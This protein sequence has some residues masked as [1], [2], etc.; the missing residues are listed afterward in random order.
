LMAGNR[1]SVAL[2]LLQES[3]PFSVGAADAPTITVQTYLTR[4]G[5]RTAFGFVVQ[6]NKLK[7]SSEV[8]YGQV[9]QFHKA[10]SKAY[11]GLTLKPVPDRDAIKKKPELL[12][13]YLEA[14]F[15][16]QCVRESDLLH[17]LNILGKLCENYP[18]YMKS[19][20]EQSQN[21]KPLLELELAT[22]YHIGELLMFLS[23]T[24]GSFEFIRYYPD[25]DLDYCNLLN[26][27]PAKKSARQ[28]S[29]RDLLGSAFERMEIPKAQIEQLL[30]ITQSRPIDDL[31]LQLQAI[32]ESQKWALIWELILDA[33]MTKGIDSRVHVSV[34]HI[35][36]MLGLSLNDLSIAEQECAAILQR[37]LIEMRASDDDNSSKN[38]KLK[39]GAGVAVGGGIAFVC[40][41]LVLPLLVPAVAAGVALG[42]GAALAIPVAGGAISA[43]IVAAGTI[44]ILAAPFL[45]FIFGA[46]GG[47]L[48]GFKVAHITE[49]ISEFRFVRVPIFTE[50]YSKDDVPEERF[51]LD[52]VNQ[53]VIDTHTGQVHRGT[54]PANN[55]EASKIESLLVHST[56]ASNWEQVKLDEQR[57]LEE[58]KLASSNPKKKPS[59]EEKKQLKE[60]RKE[61]FEQTGS[62]LTPDEVESIQTAGM[63]V[64]IGVNGW[65][66]KKEEITRNF[67]IIRE[68]H[69]GAEL[70]S[71]AWQSEELEALGKFV[72]K[73]AMHEAFL[74]TLKFAACA[75]SA[76]AAAIL[77]ALTIPL[78]LITAS[79]L[80]DNP[81]TVVANHAKRS[82]KLLAQTIIAKAAGNR[83]ITLIGWSHGARVIFAALEYLNKLDKEDYRGIVQNVFL[84][85][86]P[87]TAKVERWNAVRPLVAG[88]MVNAYSKAD[89]LLPVIHRVGTNIKTKT[90]AGMEPIALATVENLD[91]TDVVGGHL[92]YNKRLDDV[93]RL[94]NLNSSV[95]SAFSHR[96]YDAPDV[97]SFRSRIP[98]LCLSSLA[99][100][101]MAFEELERFR[102]EENSKKEKK[103]EKFSEP[104]S[105]SGNSSILY[106]G[107]YHNE[108]L[109]T[110]YQPQPPAQ[111]NS[112]YSW[113][114][115]QPL[116][117][118]YQ[119]P[120]P[121]SSNSSNPSETPSAPKNSLYQF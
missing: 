104:L 64:V 40:G 35:A 75:L 1:S 76:T 100:Q 13:Q 8:N 65:L 89:W 45:P 17:H 73:F 6:L 20:Q 69:P 27:T 79:V 109:Y 43:G 28:K 44:A 2:Q 58:A 61:R 42:A 108:P 21:K 22:R 110:A 39:I 51:E 107:P 38:R 56:Q 92:N 37:Q 95:I 68:L 111:S 3:Q 36:V 119:P 15:Q 9:E 91:L 11:P 41:L 98:D 16:Y 112:L 77:G 105:Q 52:F 62:H 74:Y 99:D 94:L 53:S 88:R 7:W 60:Y 86:A 23:Q 48:V 103:E 85:G 78:L 63:E 54:P 29:I 120:A 102:R 71:L 72:V 31:V 87:V 14:A 19:Q 113:A 84:I 46:I 50:I 90:Y 70:Y 49:G 115:P 118:S 83:P 97:P 26:I 93:L 67:A 10:I 106:G 47:G 82:G 25:A 32:P 117:T 30:N 24:W 59:K 66:W 34:Q 12:S 96:A 18:E 81:W 57:R 55:I 5:L 4:H 114:E 116:Y 33:I 121:P 80:I 101:T